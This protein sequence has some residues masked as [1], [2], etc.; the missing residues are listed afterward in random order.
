V[1]LRFLA[2]A[3]LKPAIVTGVRRGNSAVDVADARTMQ[4]HL[5]ELVRTQ[6][7][8]CVSLI[9][10]SLDV[11]S[12]VRDLTYVWEVLEADELR[13]QICRLPHLSVFHP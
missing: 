8:P 6:N 4:T 12:A 5:A 7:S 10:Q 9:P 11:G 1:K 3:N 2:D 13:N